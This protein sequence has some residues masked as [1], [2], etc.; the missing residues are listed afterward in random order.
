[1]LSRTLRLAL[2]ALLLA[3]AHAAAQAVQGRLVD[4]GGAPAG[5]VLVVLVDASG[6]QVAGALSDAAGGFSLRAPA[7][8]R[9]TLRAERVG[10]EA[11][12]TPAFDLAVG[13]TAQQR[14]VLD[15][16]HIALQTVVVTGEARRCEVRPGTG[17]Q[18]A[19]VWEEARKALNSAA[20]GQQQHWFRYR[21]ARWD[22]DLDPRSNRVIRESR[23]DTGAVA[24]HPFASPPA[25]EL[26]A[27][28]WVQNT[29]AGT[30]YYGP[31]PAALVSDEFLTDHCLRLADNSDAAGDSLV[32]VAFEPVGGRRLPDIR[33]VL[34]LDRASAEL[35]RV[36]YT[37][38]GLPTPV[39]HPRLG[40]SVEYAR[41]AGGPW[42]VRR[43]S[44]RMPQ[45]EIQQGA[46]TTP[47]RDAD[48]YTAYENAR[49]FAIRENGGEVVSTTAQN[50]APALAAAGAAAVEGVVWD[51]TR[52]APLSGARVY[53][54]GTPLETVTDS[55]GHFRIEGL[56]G[57][58]YTVAFTHYGLGPVAA[59][60]RP[61]TV[62]TQAGQT[63]TVALGVPGLATVAAAVCPDLAGQ[64]HRGVIVGS[65]KAQ[66]GAPAG[67]TVRATWGASG[68]GAARRP[69][70]YVATAADESGGFALCGVPEGQPV[71]VTA[72]SMAGT[73]AR[74]EV[75]LAAG[76]PLQRDLLLA[77]GGGGAVAAASAD[78]GPAVALPRVTA[79][80]RAALADFQRR[81]RSGRG[82]FLT[83]DQIAAKNAHRTA[84]IFMGMPGVR[85]VDDGTGALKVQMAGAIAPR[86]LGG[87]VLPQTHSQ[88]AA[89]ADARSARNAQE[90]GNGD[91][92]ATTPTAAG[93]GG[94]VAAGPISQRTGAGDCQ[95]QFFVDGTRFYPS[96]EGDI[97]GDVPLGL[98]EAVEVYRSVAETPVEFRGGQSAG[99][100]TVVIWTANATR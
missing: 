60:V 37:Y 90:R 45:V 25:A 91:P 12:V 57:G 29:P 97:S 65:L 40:G 83:R 2:P 16:P 4:D 43:W 6:R 59:S 50:G 44:I 3:T 68:T 49:L 72:G 89:Q 81:R 92:G 39:S 14:V 71:T 93:L 9:Y 98:V 66:Q 8:G 38:T 47:G 35:R 13:Q 5:Q 100:G 67:A 51:S 19:T 15:A 21:V 63:A 41:V 33:G 20:Y 85:L 70:G 24:Q 48:I 64:P 80:G 30:L 78:G 84:D 73:G 7:A 99:C 76:A 54:S 94:E 52:A 11:T 27:K 86:T 53:V 58:T 55:A 95:V 46:R 74:A 42:I 22:R 28:G 18:T 10:F 36:E 75:R 61:A 31:D 23:R 82:I 87:G 56:R 96:R 32:G 69:A 88:A 62:T 26:S 17:V 77:P 79:T 34:W 1:M